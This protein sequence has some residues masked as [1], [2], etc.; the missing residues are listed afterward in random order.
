MRKKMWSLLLIGLLAL[1]T[2]LTAC[3]GNG[4]VEGWKERNHRVGDG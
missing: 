1:S 3:G 2:I 4:G